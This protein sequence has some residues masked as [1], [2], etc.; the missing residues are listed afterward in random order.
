METKETYQIIFDELYNDVGLDIVVSTILGTKEEAIKKMKSLS[1]RIELMGNTLSVTTFEG[2]KVDNVL[3]YKDEDVQYY[4]FSILNLPENFP[5]PL[6]PE[7]VKEI[8]EHSTEEEINQFMK[9]YTITEDDFLKTGWTITEAYQ[10]MCRL[11]PN[12]DTKKPYKF[13][14]SGYRVKKQE[15]IKG[16]FFLNTVP[17]GIREALLTNESVKKDI[18]QIEKLFIKENISMEHW[19]ILEIPTNDTYCL[20][21][22]VTKEQ[23]AFTSGF[24]ENYSFVPTYIDRDSNEKEASS[25]KHALKVNDEIEKGELKNN[26]N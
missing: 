1:C 11:Y 21:N 3:L 6:K 24:R 15:K 10:E 14:S 4:S 16:A 25:I 18:E 9:L 5:P 12:H 22:I 19:G 17:E 8:F 20:Q 26:E 13:D 7:D 2:K 23:V